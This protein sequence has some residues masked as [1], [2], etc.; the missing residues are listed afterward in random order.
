MFSTLH[1]H[2]LLGHLF[3][4]SQW[5]WVS[6]LYRLSFLCTSSVPNFRILAW[7][8]IAL[9]DIVTVLLRALWLDFS[10]YN[11]NVSYY[12][13]IMLDAFGY[14]LC[15]KLCWHNRLVPNRCKITQVSKCCIMY[16]GKC[17]SVKVVGTTYI[18]KFIYRICKI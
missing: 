16:R 4:R 10:Y 14:L 2:V 17:Y 9:L 1:V 18:A 7:M 3:L 15:S 12:A 6:T 13:G 11:E 5:L 8:L